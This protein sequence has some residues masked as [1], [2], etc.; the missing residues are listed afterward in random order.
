MV[1]VVHLSSAHGDRDVRI[2]LKECA[3]LASYNSYNYFEVHQILSGV[4]ERTEL[5]VQI[6]S[7]AKY[8]NQRFKRM[9]TTVNDVYKKAL[10]LNADIYH[11]HDPELLRIALKLKRKGKVVIYL[12]LIHI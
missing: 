4:E 5:G 3:S 2:L 12:S 6:H 8:P 10:E 1:K 11:I 9:W 7:V